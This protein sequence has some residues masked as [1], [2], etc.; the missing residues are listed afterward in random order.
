[1][2]FTESQETRRSWWKPAE[3]RLGHWP[4]RTQQWLSNKCGK[5]FR[6]WSD[7]RLRRWTRRPV[8]LAAGQAQLSTDGADGAGNTRCFGP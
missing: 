1:M 5:Q 6:C 7:A 2:I 3:K 8:Q 4:G